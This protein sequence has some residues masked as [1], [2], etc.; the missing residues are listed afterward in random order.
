[1]PWTS[2]QSLSDSFRASLISLITAQGQLSALALSPT[3]AFKN[4]G[5]SNLYSMFRCFILNLPSGSLPQ[6][7]FSPKLPNVLFY[8]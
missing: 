4:L 8:C 2:L 6:G 3:T 5:S 1:M 7:H